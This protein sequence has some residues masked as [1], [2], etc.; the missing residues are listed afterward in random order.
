M[1]A[2]RRGWIVWC[3]ARAQFD[4]SSARTEGSSSIYVYLFGVLSNL[5]LVG[6]SKSSVQSRLVASD[7]QDVHQNEDEGS[8]R[9]NDGRS[10]EYLIAP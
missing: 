9:K 5:R 2:D 8:H 3:Y 6:G 7:M 10:C 4:L 1:F